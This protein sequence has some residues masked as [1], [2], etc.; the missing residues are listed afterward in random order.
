[1]LVDNIITEARSW[2]G[3]PY[4][5]QARLKGV[6]VDCAMMIADI[7]LTLNLITKEQLKMI[8][9]YPATWHVTDDKPILTDLMKEF[10][11]KQINRYD[12]QPGDVLV[13][14]VGRVPS[15]LAILTDQN[16]MIH[17]QGGTINKVTEC[18]FSASWVKRMVEV[19][20]LPGV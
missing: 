9:P 17:A 16:T 10:G 12:Y 13:F 6:G 19:Y 7:C 4:Q 20:R 3:T 2:I 14:K 18:S 15:H 8:P 1:M 11:C 5:H